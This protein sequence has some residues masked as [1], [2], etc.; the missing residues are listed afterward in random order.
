MR[1]RTTLLAALALLAA[2][3]GG[4]APE[5]SRPAP[6]PA[7]AAAA[8]EAAGEGLQL[9]LKALDGSELE[10]S[11]LRGKVVVVDVW[12]TWCGP[13]L[14][15]LPGLIRLSQARPDEIVVVGLSTDQTEK[16]LADF[17]KENPLPYFVAHADREA[18]RLFRTNALPT[19]FVLDK[20]GRLVET[21][22]G[23][24]PDSHLAEVAERYL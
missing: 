13:C 22:V 9:T 3:C 23:L 8:G 15:A 5:P 21:M 20:E 6:A 2:A 16:A 4:P 7:P 17:L 1:A 24:H 18:Q 10:L 19:V 14:R 12:A 11:S